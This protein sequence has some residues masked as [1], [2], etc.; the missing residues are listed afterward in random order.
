MIESGIE[1]VHRAVGVTD[2]ER[3]VRTKI[4]SVVMCRGRVPNES[5]I[6][7]I[8]DAGHTWSKQVLSNGESNNSRT[9]EIRGDQNIY[10]AKWDGKNQHRER[11]VNS[12]HEPSIQSTLYVKHKSYNVRARKAIF[13]CVFGHDGAGHVDSLPRTRRMRNE[14]EGGSYRKI[15][16]VRRSP[17][18][19]R[20]TAD[21][22]S[23]LR[24]YARC[25]G[26]SR[27]S[28]APGGPP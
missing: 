7:V 20:L 19:N 22:N 14:G 1:T 17:D 3:G 10:G 28:P 21:V 18:R 11:M 27:Q 23:E 24:A 8:R 16:T 13:A 9:V 12:T 2:F 25:V 6:Y 15:A 5:R 26:A 4:V